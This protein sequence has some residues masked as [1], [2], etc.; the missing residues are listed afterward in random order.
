MAGGWHAAAA[1][2]VTYGFRSGHIYTYQY[3]LE[4]KGEVGNFGG[5]QSDTKVATMAVEIRVLANRDRIMVLDVRAGESAMRRYLRANG[6]SALAPDHDPGRPVPLFWTCRSGDWG[7]GTRQRQTWAVPIGTQGVPVRWVLTLEAV[8][9]A[10]Q[11]A[12]IAI[13][14]QASL[15]ATQSVRRRLVANG[16][17]E[18]DLRDGCPQAVT[19]QLDYT[20][21]FRH[22]EIAVIRPLWAYRETRALQVTRTDGGGSK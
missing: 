17:I 21:D 2:T 9:A 3:R 15:P 6:E 19:L 8:D 13:A 20:L 5:R 18:M 1:A 10:K 22:K 7:V 14:G 4:T 16:R 11:R 12:T